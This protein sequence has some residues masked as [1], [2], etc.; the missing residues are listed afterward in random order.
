MTQVDKTTVCLFDVDGTLTP[1]RGRITPEVDNVLRRLA[2][3]VSVGL[4]SGS[5]IC[6]TEEQVGDQVDGE[7]TSNFGNGN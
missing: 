3:K 4:V 1:A 7:L 2:E 6:K 5:D